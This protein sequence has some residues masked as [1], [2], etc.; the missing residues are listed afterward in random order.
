MGLYDSAE[1]VSLEVQNNY[2]FQRSIKAYYEA[3]TL[4]S[5]KVLEIGTG[6]GYGVEIIS[7]IAKEFITIDKFDTQLD[8]SK[9]PNV[10][11]MQQNVPPI[12]FEANTFDSVIT[13]QVVEHIK[14]DHAFIS[15]IHRVLKPGGKLIITTPNI[16]MSITRNPW[17]VR[18]YTVD[19]FKRL[20]SKYFSRVEAKGVYGNEKSDLYYENNKKSV[21]KILKWDVLQ[22]NR[23]LPRR[24]LQVPY[25]IMNQRNRKKLMVQNTDLANS[26]SHEDFFVK[27]A[28]DKCFDL[29]YIATK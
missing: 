26:F 11:F 25:D 5:G 9:H 22:M 8:F 4:A 10:T 28:D 27:P 3:A 24:I 19:Q 29:F 18:E 23:W 16:K 17:H 14:D 12:N 13:F 1:R 20:L 15:E 21:Q 6:S 2:L 7:D